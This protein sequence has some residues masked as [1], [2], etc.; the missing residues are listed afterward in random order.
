MKNKKL[1]MAVLLIIAAVL[2]VYVVYSNSNKANQSDTENLGNNNPVV[3]EAP[4]SDNTGVTN[5]NAPYITDV[6]VDT[7]ITFFASETDMDP[8]LEKAIKKEID[9]PGKEDVEATRYYYNYINLNE[10]ETMEVFV[11][12]VGPYTSMSDG[13]IGLLF[14]AKAD[15]YQ[16]L[17]KFTMITNPILISNQVTNGWHDIILN[18]TGSGAKPGRILMQYDGN[19]YPDPGEAPTI[20]DDVQV[21]GTAILSDDYASDLQSGRGL[22]LSYE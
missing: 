16:L 1:L 3:T 18:F 2:I 8:E 19:S 20:A 17:Q 13:D 22:Y 15:G 10:D 21:G 6:P 9:F 4:A 14:S 11:Q 12:L 5:N 7:E